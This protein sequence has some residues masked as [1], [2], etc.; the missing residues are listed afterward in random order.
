MVSSSG[1]SCHSRYWYNYLYQ[2][3][4][5]ARFHRTLKEK[6]LKYFIASGSTRWIDII[7][8]IIKNYNNTEIRTIGCTPTQ[9]SNHLIQSILINK[10]QEKTNQIENKD[11]KYNIGD[12]CRIKENTKIFDKMKRKYSSDIYTIIKV[13]K[14]SVDIENDE[15]ELNG[16]KKTDIIIIQ[17]SYN[18]KNVDHIK[19]VE[20]EHRTERILNSEGVDKSSILSYTRR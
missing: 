3:N 9:V 15:V 14:N 11:I 8:K 7:N 17:E 19:Q 2:S 4:E 6:L 10:S 16:V 18:N 20:K 1:G 12:R 5:N 13:N